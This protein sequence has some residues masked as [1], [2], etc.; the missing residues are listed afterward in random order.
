M[1]EAPQYAGT[2]DDENLFFRLNDQED[3]CP[4]MSKHFLSLC[5]TGIVSFLPTKQFP[6]PPQKGD[7]AVIQP[8]AK[9]NSAGHIEGYDGKDWISDFVQTGFWPGASDRSEKPADAIYRP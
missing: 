4:S 3:V 8:T 2:R 6:I 5:A 7:V 9:G 1:L